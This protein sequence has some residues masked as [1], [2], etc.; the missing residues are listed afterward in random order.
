MNSVAK[1]L[2]LSGSIVVLVGIFLGYKLWSF[3]PV[4]APLSLPTTGHATVR[5]PSLPPIDRA[6]ANLKAEI[7]QIVAEQRGETNP[8][9]TTHFEP[10]P[11]PA[12]PPP[13]PPQPAPPPSPPPP[14]PPSTREVALRYQGF[15]ET[16]DGVKTAYLRRE[17]TLLVLTLE[18]AVVADWKVGRIEPRQLVLVGTEGKEMPLDFN[19][20][21]KI[22][23]PVEAK[24]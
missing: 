15:F 18:E 7:A 16:T 8:F 5:I 6:F 11:P 17:E 3:G 13:P 1:N 21:K 9:H 4:G 14:P 22:N 23:V 19:Q 12:P 24:K 10:P 20:V 2:V